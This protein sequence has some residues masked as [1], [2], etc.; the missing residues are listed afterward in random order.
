MGG[1][2]WWCQCWEGV[3]DADGVGGGGGAG[4]MVGDTAKTSGWLLT[5]VGMPTATGAPSAST[6]DD[7]GPGATVG[8]LMMRGIGYTRGGDCTYPDN[9]HS[10][11]NNS[12]DH[13]STAVEGILVFY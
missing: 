8:E 2:W 6:D 1:W 11:E 13:N 4:G 5:G 12:T 7:T 3:G 10:N 9:S